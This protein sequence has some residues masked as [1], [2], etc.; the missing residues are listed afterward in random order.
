MIIIPIFG[1]N[2]FISFLGNILLLLFLIPL[3]LLL[4]IFIGFNSYKSKINTCNNCG[5]ISLGLNEI[6]MN[7]GA[8]ID[9]FNKENQ[10]DKKPSERTIE[11]Q[12]EE[13]N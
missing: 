4:L 13:I 12:A 2:F 5:A 3:L 7:C 11:V 1:F 9:D 8:S 10:F 6:C